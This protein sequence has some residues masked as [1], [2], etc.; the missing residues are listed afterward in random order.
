[1]VT[2]KAMS[3]SGYRERRI[4][5]DSNIGANSELNTSLVARNNVIHM[6]NMIIELQEVLATNAKYANEVEKLNF[7]LKSMS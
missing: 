2:K 7:M 5:T 6:K 1:M 3:E 4:V